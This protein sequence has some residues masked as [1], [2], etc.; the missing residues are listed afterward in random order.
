[1]TREESDARQGRLRDCR[2]WGHDWIFWVVPQPLSV[3]LMPAENFDPSK[4]VIQK[5]GRCRQCGEPY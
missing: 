3:L 4:V 1:M 5:A 2:V